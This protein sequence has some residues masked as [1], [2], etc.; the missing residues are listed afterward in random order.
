M[1]DADAVFQSYGR[2][3]N[4][5]HFFEDFYTIFMGKSPEVRAMFD[6]TNMDSQRGLLRSGILNLVLC[7]R[8]MPETKIRAL[9]ES[10]SKKNMN[11]NPSFYGIWLDA[12]MEALHKHDEDFSESLEVSWRSALLPSIEIMQ[13]MYDQ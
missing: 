5:P 8:G 6:N 12:L 13:N 9:G 3:C 4:S 10:H 11:I 7:A 1:F 2:A